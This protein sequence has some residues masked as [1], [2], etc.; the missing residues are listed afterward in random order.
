MTTTLSSKGQVVLPRLAR[1]KLGLIPGTKLRCEVHGDSIVLKPE[2]PRP[3]A[4]QLV[5]DKLTGL[6]VAKRSSP[7]ATVTSEM[8]K[9]LL[10]DFP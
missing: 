9:A 7:D 2:I 10:S 5:V 6:R 4:T 1:T 3:R 8:V